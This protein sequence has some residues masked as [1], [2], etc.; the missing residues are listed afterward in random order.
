MFRLIPIFILIAVQAQAGAWPR[1]EGETFVSLA[2]ETGP[3]SVNDDMQTQLIQAIDGYAMLYVERGLPNDTT[4]GLDATGKQ[5]EL[6]KAIS[7]MR[8][9]IALPGKSAVLAVEFGLGMANEEFALRP[10]LSYGRGFSLGSLQG[11]L[12]VDGRALLIDEEHSTLEAD[13]TLGFKPWTDHML[14][15][16]LQTGTSAEHGT[17]ATFAPSYVLPVSPGRHLEIGM[18]TG[19]ESASEIKVKFGLWHRF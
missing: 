12:S 9:P 2:V 19:V 5:T 3:F 16:Q 13:M 11:W 6:T 4:L 1:A 17:H 14:I 10:G 18:A 7:F 8:W 15:L